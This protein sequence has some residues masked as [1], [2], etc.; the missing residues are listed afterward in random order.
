MPANTTK[1]R[2]EQTIIWAFLQVIAIPG[3]VIGTTA[4][5]AGNY[6]LAVGGYIV[7]IVAIV[8]FVVSLQ[9]EFA[10]EED[11]QQAIQEVEESQVEVGAEK[12]GDAVYHAIEEGKNKQTQDEQQSGESDGSQPGE[13]P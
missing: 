7:G 6:P 2:H 1:S 4:F 10:W 8:A 3:L 9:Y 11:L 5:Q 13:R 12:V